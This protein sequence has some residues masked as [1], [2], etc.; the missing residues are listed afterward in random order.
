MLGYNSEV[1]L[2]NFSKKGKLNLQY[3]VNNDLT[4]WLGYKVSKAVVGAEL[5]L[6][7]LNLS[8]LWDAA[9]NPWTAGVCMTRKAD[10]NF[11]AG[12]GVKHACCDYDVTV[13][14]DCDLNSKVSW[15]K[16]VSEHVKMCGSLSVP[17]VLLSGGGNWKTDLKYGT[18]M[19]IDMS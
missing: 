3:K 1:D 10:G 19:T 9:G 13:A 15:V 4:A 7:D 14:A 8:V 16:K 18:T 6:G 2:Q 5:P 12:V 17:S 11:K